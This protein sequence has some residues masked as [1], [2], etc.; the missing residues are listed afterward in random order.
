MADI[1]TIIN[2]INK[3]WDLL[4]IFSFE[5]FYLYI[6]IIFYFT[7]RAFFSKNK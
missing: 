6:L 7:S 2:G 3:Y 5:I 1:D 4:A